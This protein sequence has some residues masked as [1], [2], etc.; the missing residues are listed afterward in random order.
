MILSAVHTD[1][2]RRTAEMRLGRVTVAERIARYRHSGATVA[3]GR[4]EQLAWLLERRLFDRGCA[5]V[6]ADDA[7]MDSGAAGLLVLVLSDE[8]THLPA[9]DAQAADQI[10]RGLEESGIL[11]TNESLTGGEGI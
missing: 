11:L 1:R 2:Q 8:A 7:G 10:I 3:L 6:I 4:R 5:V 9:D